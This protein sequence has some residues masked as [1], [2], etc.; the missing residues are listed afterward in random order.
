MLDA[1][2]EK[3]V[4][5]PVARVASKRTEMSDAEEGRTVSEPVAGGVS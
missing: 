5:A 1:K 2:E 4:S 3:T